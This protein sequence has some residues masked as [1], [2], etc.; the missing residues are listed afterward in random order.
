MSVHSPSNEMSIQETLVWLQEDSLSPND[1]ALRAYP[2][3]PAVFV[4]DDAVVEAEAY[5]L[6]RIVFQY[7]CL[8]ETQAELLRGDTVQALLWKAKQCGVT[9]IAVTWS[10][11]PRFKDWLLAVERYLPVEVFTT[12]AF[13]PADLDVDLRRFSRFWKRAERYAFGQ[14]SSR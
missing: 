11:Q 8:L 2:D 5:S 6:K 12:D 1:P 3:A 14:Q 9:R 10:V 13:V 7:E 4:W